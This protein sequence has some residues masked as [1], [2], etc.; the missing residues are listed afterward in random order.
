V[1]VALAQSFK[2]IDPDLK[3][4][5]TKHWKRCFQVFDLLSKAAVS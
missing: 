5:E 2:I 4:P 3:N 1:S